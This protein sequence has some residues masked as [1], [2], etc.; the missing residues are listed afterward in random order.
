MYISS[1]LKWFPTY[2]SRKTII[3]VTSPCPSPRSTAA[4][5]ASAVANSSLCW[6]SMA[7]TPTDRSSVHFLVMPIL[8]V[9]DTPWVDI[10]P[11]R[12]TLRS[13]PP[14]GERSVPAHP[15]SASPERLHEGGDDVVHLDRLL[16]HRDVPSA[17]D[18][19]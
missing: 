4:R 9:G 14:S 19:L 8:L 2:S 10:P 11:S 15:S 18:D 3:F 5:R 16:E 13:F 6:A 17:P 12:I 1:M 7:S